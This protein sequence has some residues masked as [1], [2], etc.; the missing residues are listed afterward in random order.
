MESDKSATV[1]ALGVVVLSSVGMALG[2]HGANWGAFPQMVTMGILGWASWALLTF[3]IGSRLLPQPATRVD[4]GELLRTLGFSTAPGVLGALSVLPGLTVPATLVAGVW[5]LLSMVVAVRQALDYDRTSRAIA[6]V[7]SLAVDRSGVGRLQRCVDGY[8]DLELRRW[9]MRSVLVVYGTGD[10]QT[11]KIARYIAHRL[12][13]SGV[14]VVL[15]NA[16]SGSDPNPARFGS[17]IVA[18]S[19]HAGGYQRAVRKWVGR[20][21]EQLNRMRTGVR[22]GLSWRARAQPRY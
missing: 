13:V 9:M 2:F 15:V 8:C 10:G 21:V 22:V 19:V 12:D 6:V 20:H 1:Q 11:E 17:V 16:A 5:M 3:E 14:P 4:V 7:P 18:A